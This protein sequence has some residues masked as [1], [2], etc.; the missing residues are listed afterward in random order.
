VQQLKFF[1]WSVSMVCGTTAGAADSKISNQPVTFE[2]NW[3]QSFDANS[4]WISKLRRSL[5]P[6]YDDCLED[7]QNCSVLYCVPQLYPV[8]CTLS[9]MS[10]LINMSS[11]YGWTRACWF[12]L[13]FWC[14]FLNSGQCIC[15]RVSYF[16][17]CVCI[18]WAMSLWWLSGTLSAGIFNQI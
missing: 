8:I 12:R 9:Y 10:M 16:V 6:S 17:I 5:Y 3:I 4:N 13:S 11:S 18:I 1:C 2:S 7:Y 14:V 15:H